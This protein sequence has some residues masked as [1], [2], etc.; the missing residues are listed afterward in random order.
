MK[1]SLRG[2]IGKVKKIHNNK[3]NGAASFVAERSP[4]SA[5]FPTVNKG[6]QTREAGSCPLTYRVIISFPSADAGFLS[7]FNRII[8]FK[9]VKTVFL[10]YFAIFV[11]NIKFLW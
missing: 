10:I 7:N 1:I 4:W 2:A 9:T 3:I 5:F 11:A 8:P 6:M